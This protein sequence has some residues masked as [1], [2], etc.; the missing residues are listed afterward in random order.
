MRQR[1]TGNSSSTRPE[2][3]QKLYGAVQL[4]RILRSRMTRDSSPS[5]ESHSNG[6]SP[7]KPTLPRRNSGA[8]IVN[9]RRPW[10]L[11]IGAHEY[12]N[13]LANWGVLPLLE[14][15]AVSSLYI[16]FLAWFA[17]FEGYATFSKASALV[18]VI[19]TILYVSLVYVGSRWMRQRRRPCKERVTEY[20]VVYNIFQLAL[21]LFAAVSIS[22]EARRL[23]FHI[24]G[25][26]VDPRHD[27][28]AFLIWGHYHNQYIEMFDTAV[29]VLRKKWDKISWMHVYLRLLTTWSWFFV[30]RYGGCGGDSYFPAMVQSAVRI[31]VYFFYLCSILGLPIP[32]L[33]E[34][35]TKIQLLQ[36]L[37]LLVHAVLVFFA[38]SMT[39]HFVGI[40]LFVMVNSLVLLT[41]F[42]YES[43][44]ESM[45]SDNHHTPRVVF[46]F[47]SSG[48][49][50]LYHFGVA[51][52]IAQSILPKMAPGEVAFSGSSGGSLTAVGLAAQVNMSDLK[53]YVVQKCWPRIRPCFWRVLQCVEDAMDDNL[54]DDA[55]ILCE[56]KVQMLAT[57]VLFQP[58]FLMAE[59]KTEFR[60][61]EHLKETCRASC[62]IPGLGNIIPYKTSDGYYIDGM[63]WSSEWF[64]PWRG[65][66]RDDIVIKISAMGFPNC[67]IQPPVWIPPWWCVFPPQPSVLEGMFA[68]GYEDAEQ[69]FQGE[70]TKDIDLDA[71][72]KNL[73]LGRERDFLLAVHRA[74]RNFFFCTLISIGGLVWALE[75][76][77][78]AFGAVSA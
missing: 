27:W 26:Q 21:S 68:T 12:R 22:Q 55:H 17:K 42:Q 74:W 28:M 31:P 32:L 45:E 24:W 33:K 5:R 19:G 44:K 4:G 58:P 18:P 43:S 62:H 71:Q 6:A 61:L 38:G 69:F 13:P 52:F 40:Q 65:F 54:P 2:D 66:R 64:C 73:V 59:V 37:V 25:N 36:F 76:Y 14:L 51:T 56:K 63:W 34:T 49:L 48:W 46:S 3:Q 39:F 70:L 29:N 67:N 15:G 60:S 75:R 77:F 11:Q 57:K 72:K 8:D 47:D 9:E 20:M 10:F 35:V 41:N 78:A 53:N 16:L 23:N 50:F 1:G 7:E 30:V